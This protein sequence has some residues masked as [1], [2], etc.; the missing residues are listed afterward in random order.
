M[1]GSEKRLWPLVGEACRRGLWCPEVDV[2]METEEEE[3]E[4]GGQEE[5]GND[6]SDSGLVMYRDWVLSLRRPDCSLLLTRLLNVRLPGG[7][8]E[9]AGPEA[10]DWEWEWTPGGS[11]TVLGMTGLR[12]CS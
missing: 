2:T 8:R 6:R 11:L 9:W 10:G 4:E 5:K 7:M 3:A 1:S 12:R